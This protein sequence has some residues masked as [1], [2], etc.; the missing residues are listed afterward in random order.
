MAVAGG[1]QSIDPNDVHTD[2]RELRLGGKPIG[3]IGMGR[4]EY[5]GHIC[6]DGSVTGVLISHGYYF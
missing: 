4:L 3:K 6:G 1:G 5:V 2:T